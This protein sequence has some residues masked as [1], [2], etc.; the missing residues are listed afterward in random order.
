MN[1]YEKHAR[2][3]LPKGYVFLG[4]GGD[5]ETPQGKSFGGLATYDDY[6]DEW[7]ESRFNGVANDL[8]YAAPIGS[9]ICELNGYVS[10]PKNEQSRP[11]FPE[12]AEARKTYPV[13]TFIKDY[14]PN[15]I[16]AL[17]HHSLMCQRQHGEASNGAAMEWLKDKSVGD[18]N[19]LVRH[20]ME[21]DFAAMAWR[22]LEL[23]E[24]ELTKQPKKSE[25]ANNGA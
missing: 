1:K 3:A 23:L 11:I 8:F 17:A 10:E 9:E 15:A 2:S 20:Y 14:F 21:G 22:G 25:N 12:D 4:K 5:F 16:A 6:Y 18:G 13:G 7:Y 19:Q 24:R